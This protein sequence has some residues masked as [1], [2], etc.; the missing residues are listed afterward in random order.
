MACIVVCQYLYQ[1]S[2]NPNQISDLTCP[3]CPC[4]C[5]IH[6]VTI[7]TIS[8]LILIFSSTMELNLEGCT[9]DVGCMTLNMNADKATISIIDHCLIGRILTDKRIRFKHLQERLNHLWQP[10]KGVALFL[11][12]KNSNYSNSI[13]RLMLRR[14]SMEGLGFLRTST[15]FSKRSR[16]V[17]S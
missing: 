1:K 11:W 9:L 5:A 7:S 13:I 17:M 2:A 10:G 6:C 15:S 4:T 3:H 16:Q 12:I 8:T 14:F